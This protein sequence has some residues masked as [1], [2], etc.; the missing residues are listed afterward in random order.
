MQKFILGSPGEIEPVKLLIGISATPQRFQTLLQQT[1]LV[2]P[3]TERFVTVRPEEVRAPGLLKDKIILYHPEDDQP[4]DYSLLAEAARKWQDMRNRWRDYSQ[5]QGIA[6]VQPALVIQVED[7]NERHL[8]HTSLGQV[9]QVLET[10]IGPI[11]DE[12]LAHSFQEDR[13]I[14]EGGHK[15]RKI[16][17]S[18]IQEESQV[19]FIFFKLSL[20]TGWDCPRAEVMMSFRRARDHTS[21][22]GKTANSSPS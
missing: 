12:E 16:E 9:L 5:A 20:T 14:E 18:R 3:R 15:I 6:P 11:K 4:S 17:A 21:T 19:K 10:A 13:E 1:R 8:T 7:G 22:C 2:A